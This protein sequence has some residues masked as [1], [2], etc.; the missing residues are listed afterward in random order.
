MRFVA[1]RAI[2]LLDP[3]LQQ[4]DRCL[5]VSDRHHDPAMSAQ[6]VGHWLGSG[7]GQSVLA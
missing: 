5:R 7:D 3:V 6:A 2:A 1:I 4:V